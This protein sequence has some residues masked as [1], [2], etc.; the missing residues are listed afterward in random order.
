MALARTALLR[1]G[2]AVHSLGP[3]LTLSSIVF[4]FESLRR[5]LTRSGLVLPLA[6][7]GLLFVLSGCSTATYDGIEDTTRCPE[8]RC[9]DVDDPN[10]QTVFGTGGIGT[11]F[12]DGDSAD[13]GGGGSGIGVNAFLWRASLDTFAFLPPFSADPLGGVIIYDWYAPAETPGERLKVT[14]YILDT[15]LRADAVQVN[16]FRQL[17]G[18]DGSWYDAAVEEGTNAALEDAILTRARQ[19]RIAQ[20]G[21]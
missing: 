4:P 2:A 18:A 12:S 15:R 6:A 17:R 20:L 11:L 14:V 5:I 1:Q 8:G 10:R 7:A 19:L 9:P 3:A 16:V 21:Q 13:Q